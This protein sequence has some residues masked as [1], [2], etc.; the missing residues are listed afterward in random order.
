MDRQITTL[1]DQQDESAWS[2]RSGD[3]CGGHSA[4][5]DW[6]RRLNGEWSRPLPTRKSR[7]PC[8][9]LPRDLRSLKPRAFTARIFL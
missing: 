6:R 1:A 4:G 5:R 2:E 7:T 9:A 8:A 3:G